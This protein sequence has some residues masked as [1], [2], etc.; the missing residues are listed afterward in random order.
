[1]SKMYDL[2]YRL[3][4]R[5]NKAIVTDEQSLTNEQK[6][7]VKANLGIVETEPVTPN[8]AENDPE[9]SGYIE[10][11]THWCTTGE[12]AVYSGTPQFSSC[13]VDYLGA[14]TGTFGADL[15]NEV[16]L[17]DSM[18]NSPSA[19]PDTFV[20]VVDGV[21][22][23]VPL[24]STGNMVQDRVMTST[25]EYISVSP[26]YRGYTTLVLYCTDGLQQSQFEIKTNGVVYNCLDDGFLSHSIARVADLSKKCLSV[27][28]SQSLTEQ[29]KTIAKNNLG[30]PGIEDG[31]IRVDSAYT[32][33]S[34]WTGTSNYVKSYSDGLAILYKVPTT[35]PGGGNVYLNINSL[36]AVPIYANGASILQKYSKGTYLLLVYDATSN[37]WN[38]AC[39]LDT[40]N[41]TGIQQSSAKLYLLGSPNSPPY[42]ADGVSFTK[43][44]CYAGT[45]GCLYSN[46]AKVSTVDDLDAISTRLPYII[47]GTYQYTEEGNIYTITQYDSE[48][49]LATHNNG[50]GFELHLTSIDDSDITVAYPSYVCIDG[51]LEQSFVFIST[52]DCRVLH[53]SLYNGEVGEA[54]EVPFASA[55]TSDAYVMTGTMEYADD[56]IEYS[57]TQTP[58]IDKIR[59]CMS[60][61]KPCYLYLRDINDNQYRIF[62][63]VMEYEADDSIRFQH[64]DAD[65]VYTVDLCVSDPTSL[66]S[67]ARFRLI[68]SSAV[69]SAE[70]YETPDITETPYDYCI[71]TN[72]AVAYTIKNLTSVFPVTTNA[73]GSYR[74]GLS[75]NLLN[76]YLN[77]GISVS[78]RFTDC[79]G[80]VVIVPRIGPIRA[81]DGTLYYDFALVYP[82]L[83]EETWKNTYRVLLSITSKDELV[84]KQDV[85]SNATVSAI[86]TISEKLEA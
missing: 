11:R 54:I 46:S 49:V 8:W 32:S 3:I 45:D 73:D 13:P 57:F 53:L 70:Q 75:F 71:P 29:Q 15:G 41:T 59:E 27:D 64:I 40:R 43:I 52:N 25:G 62:T 20:I 78:L 72:A 35:G 31:V 61:G 77:K 12:V 28:S 21:R 18:K 1:M 42:G 76:R 26:T 24:S 34:N 74:V 83:T 60:S 9:A 68:T 4:N 36:G 69:F 63:P 55:D 51:L 80:Q 84:V 7:R 14:G 47:K 79:D 65:I 37:R 19:L 39:D 6:A 23:T 17:P 82:G 2:L 50:G 56:E 85:V 86:N 58:Q 67:R 66:N 81:V 38:V 16:N 33:S 5:V 48:Q 44:S 30:L 22:Y 10:G